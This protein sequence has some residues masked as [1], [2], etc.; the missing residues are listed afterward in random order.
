MRH[1]RRQEPTQ[2]GSDEE[3]NLS[4][5]EIDIGT[6]A[7]GHC[8]KP[9]FGRPMQSHFHSQP[10]R[11]GC[12]VWLCASMVAPQQFRPA[13]SSCSVSSPPFQ[14]SYIFQLCCSHLFSRRIALV[15][16]IATTSTAQRSAYCVSP[17]CPRT[18]TAVS[19]TVAP[20]AT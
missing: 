12:L 7:V 1:R 14:A 19:Q 9:P 17:E 20:A 16:Y 2:H 18:C 5:G 13:F 6:E 15:V 11:R 8:G 3:T 4:R 10:G